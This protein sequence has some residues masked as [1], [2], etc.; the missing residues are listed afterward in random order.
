MPMERHI[1]D[2]CYPR[3]SACVE[4]GYSQDII[5]IC[6]RVIEVVIM[7]I[8]KVEIMKARYEYDFISDNSFV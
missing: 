6:R 5:S 3:Q 2:M 1:G 8:M 4:R 7:E